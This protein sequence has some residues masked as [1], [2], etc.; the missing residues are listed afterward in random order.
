MLFLNTI[1]PKTLALLKR[2]LALPVLSETRLV[3]GTALALQLGHR[4][5]VDLDIFGKWN[6]SEDM[7][8]EFSAIGQ[9]EKESGTP[10]G[11]MAFFYI[12]GVKIDCVAY[13]MY[14]W[15]EPPV[16]EDGIRLAGIKDIAAM[17][18]NA[19]TN[20]GSRKDFVDIARL[21][22]DYSLVDIFAWYRKKYPTAN[23]ALAMRSMSYFVDAE[24]M[25]M[26][27]MLIPF[28][29]EEAKDRIR[30]AVRKFAT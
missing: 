10:D 4:I 12:D 26:P 7:L 2:L 14:E 18:V 11:K 5:S 21:L 3:G 23:P 17:K 24:T 13:D 16:E 28:D 25:P 22:D 15:L 6:Y 20:R 30:A 27:K 8:G 29:W 9:A 1:E 19:I